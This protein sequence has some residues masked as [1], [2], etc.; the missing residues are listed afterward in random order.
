MKP[1]AVSDC[2]SEVIGKWCHSACANESLLIPSLK[3]KLMYVISRVCLAVLQGGSPRHDR[4]PYCMAVSVQQPPQLHPVP[5]TQVHIIKSS[6]QC[7]AREGT[8]A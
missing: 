6:S 4:S 3:E 8:T 2:C 7:S 1:R 5:G